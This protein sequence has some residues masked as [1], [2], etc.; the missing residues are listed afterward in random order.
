M[1][2]VTSVVF[3]FLLL[4]QESLYAQ[5]PVG[6]WRDHFS[7]GNTHLLCYEDG[8]IFCGASNGIFSY[9]LTTGEVEKITRVNGLSEVG[10]SALCYFPSLHTLAIGY[11]SGNIDLLVH[12]SVV[13]IPFIKEKPLS[14]SKVINRFTLF[15]GLIYTSTDFGVVVVDPVKKEIKETYYIGDNGTSIRVSCL[16]IFEGRFWAATSNG[17]KSALTSDPLL[18]SFEHWTN[19]TSFT[20]PTAECVGVAAQNGYLFALERQENANDILWRFDGN[21][22]VEVDRPLPATLHLSVSPNKILVTSS[23]G[24]QTYTFPGIRDE[25]LLSESLFINP[26]A[27]ISIDADRIA[28]ADKFNGLMF[29]NPQALMSICPNGPANNNHFAVAASSKRVVVAS[30]GYDA[31]FTNLWHPFLVHNFTDESW[32]DYADYGY[33][34]AVAVRF[35]PGNPSDYYVASW[36]GGLYHFHD[37][38]MVEHF[39]PE[40]SSLQSI[41]PNAPYCRISG[42][43]FDSKGNLWVANASVANPISV[44]KTDGTWVSFPYASAIN[45]DKM[46]TLSYSSYGTLWLV[47]PRG[48]GLFALNPGSSID[49]KDDDRYRKLQP[50]SSSGSLFNV[51]INALAFDRDDYLWLGTNQGVLVSY[52]PGKIFDGGMYFQKIKIPDVVEGLAVYL[53]ETEEV[54]SITVDGGNRKWFGTARSG[55][56]LFSPDGTRELAHY[57]TQNSPLPSDRIA[58]VKVHPTSGEVFIAT[59]KGLVSFRSN[60][61]QPGS[62]FGKVYA[63]PNPVRPEYEG[64]ITI[65]GLMENTLVKITDISGNLVFETRSV[66]GMA[67]WNGKNSKGQRAASGVYLVFCSAD[68]GKQ[69]AVTKILFIR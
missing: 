6:S 53:L 41:F 69:T 32:S 57:T 5:I 46:S 49:T 12:G 22:W 29:G 18:V 56:F 65:T 54:T 16:E 2:R 21:S 52:N 27:A 38:S 25:F 45:A 64:D 67:T 9:D 66:G 59:D 30:G 37:G 8:K 68:Q 7:F 61:N 28:I 39:T 10:I 26:Q 15:N 63:F 42:I 11:E 44:R 13:N 40:N 62:G 55:V 60:A 51:D 17:L 19:E 3:V 58:D 50:A 48:Q 43:D 36:G 33:H 14:G 24:I 35:N 20:N 47:L 4:L 23:N 34:D 31:T 1:A